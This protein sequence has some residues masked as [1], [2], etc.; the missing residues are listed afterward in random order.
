MKKI[1]YYLFFLVLFLY[2][3][4]SLAASC[5]GLRVEA[6]DERD[7]CYQASP[8]LLELISCLAGRNSNL[9]ITSIGDDP[10][11]FSHCVTNWTDDV[12]SHHSSSDH[13]G[14][15]L[16]DNGRAC[17]GGSY[18]LDLRAANATQAAPI[19]SQVNA[20]G[21][22]AVFESSPGAPHVHASINDCGGSS[23]VAT[24]IKKKP[25]CFQ[26]EFPIPGFP[27]N[28]E[29]YTDCPNGLI[30]SSKG[31]AII[32]YVNALYKYGAG[33]A[34]LMAM[35]MIVFAAWQWIMASGNAGK[36]DNAKETI[37]G[38]L[39]GLTL[40]FAGNLL[41][42]NITT[43]LVQ[44]DGLN[45][46]NIDTIQSNEKVYVAGYPTGQ[47]LEEASAQSCGVTFESPSSP[48][49]MCPMGLACT[50]GYLCFVQDVTNL[51]DWYPCSEE[52]FAKYGPG[53]Q[54]QNIANFDMTDYPFRLAN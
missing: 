25:I 50:N 35:F 46:K 26:P 24:V 44:F 9:I 48:G 3:D 38:A 29:K 10:D 17:A 45:I 11:Y 13:Y 39:L 20:C 5:N 54:C 21:A 19:I 18:A 12:C 6:G 42:S 2:P 41:L 51:G 27:L 30:L 23:G 40:L 52:N 53:C 31:D 49:L 33:L 22:Q 36:I 37:R 14:G 15:T 8:K 1:F 16:V 47:C 34:G 32:V 43:R 28:D 7:R 4:S